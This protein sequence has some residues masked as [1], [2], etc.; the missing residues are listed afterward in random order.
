MCLTGLT[1]LGVMKQVLDTTLQW[2]L[3]AFSKSWAKAVNWESEWVSCEGIGLKMKGNKG[4]ED[5]RTGEL[6]LK[7]KGS[8]GLEDWRTGGSKFLRVR[9]LRGFSR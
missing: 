1:E 7:M 9:G 5:W 8:K 2:G 4:L 6:D 3:Y